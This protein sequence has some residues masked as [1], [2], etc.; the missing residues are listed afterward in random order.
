[1][2]EISLLVL[3]RADG[4]VVEIHLDNIIKKQAC[5]MEKRNIDMFPDRSFCLTVANLGSFNVHPPNHLNVAED[6]NAP[7]E[8][9]DVKD[10]RY[11]YTLAHK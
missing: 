10:K 6:E 1:M 5:M 3:K 8:I 2:F 9:V 11:L 7:V 4:L